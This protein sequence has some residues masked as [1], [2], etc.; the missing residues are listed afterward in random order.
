MLHTGALT[1]NAAGAMVFETTSVHR[2]TLSSNGVLI[3]PAADASQPANNLILQGTTSGSAPTNAVIS[4]SASKVFALA[5]DTGG[6]INLSIGATTAFSLST[7]SPGSAA[8][9]GSLLVNNG[10]GVNLAAITL[11][12]SDSGGTGFRA[13]LVAN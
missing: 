1:L 4:Q 3:P 11:G 6:T 10:S 7:A 2:L 12:A 8:T 5:S 13:L 9:A